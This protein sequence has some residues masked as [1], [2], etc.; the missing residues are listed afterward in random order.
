MNVTRTEL[1]AE[2]QSSRQSIRRLIQTGVLKVLPNGKLD[3]DASLA[4]IA[5]NSSGFGGGWSGGLR[6]RLSLQERAEKLLRGERHEQADE[7]EE[8]DIESG[9][10]SVM[11]IGGLMF[12]SE[13]IRDQGRQDSLRDL[14]LDALAN[15]DLVLAGRKLS[16]KQK[17]LAAAN[18]VALFTYVVSGWFDELLD[19]V[20]KGSALE[21]R[22][23][24]RA[25]GD[26]HIMYRD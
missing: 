3:R 2:L 24:L 21:F 5:A 16:R 23:S 11:F 14:A 12:L 20:G 17:A 13:Q 4:A 18:L 19:F 15:V 25:W 1:A 10:P 7:E 22:E 26:E 9:K 8:A 6:G